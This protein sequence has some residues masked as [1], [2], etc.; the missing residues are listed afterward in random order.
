MTDG[1]NRFG[2]SAVAVTNISKH[3]FWLLIN[4]EEVFLPFEKF[5]WFLDAP[6]GKVVQRFDGFSA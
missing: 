5:P 4:E 1:M 6:I 2:T 3:G